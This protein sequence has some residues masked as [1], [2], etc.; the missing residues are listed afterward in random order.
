MVNLVLR[1]L[2]NAALLL[3]ITNIVPG[4]GFSGFYAALVTVAILGLINAFIRPLINLFTLPINL[5]TLGFFGFVI[6]AVLFWF[7]ATIVDGF[8]VANFTA[9]FLGALLFWLGSFIISWVFK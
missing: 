3:L 8:S 5:L 1:W 6:N 4:I 9:A 2:F 7:T